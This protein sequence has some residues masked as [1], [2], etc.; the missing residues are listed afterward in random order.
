MPTYDYHCK[1]NN[2]I[3]EVKHSMK[4]KL[5]TWGELCDKAKINIGNTPAGA[6]ITR[7]ITQCHVNTTSPPM[8]I[9]DILPK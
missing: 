3:I 9:T 5:E 2:Q 7:I 4:E 8:K 6:E 1:A